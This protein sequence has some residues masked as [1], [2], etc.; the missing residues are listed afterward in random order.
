MTALFP[1]ENRKIQAY[2]KYPRGKVYV[3]LVRA[4]VRSKGM[5]FMYD[6]LRKDLL[7]E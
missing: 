5:A 1:L 2:K 7:N 4:E 6:L 3:R